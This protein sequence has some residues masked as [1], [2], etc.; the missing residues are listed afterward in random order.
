MPK[1]PPTLDDVRAKHGGLLNGKVYR[2]LKNLYTTNYF[3]AEF[4]GLYST[5]EGIPM[6]YLGNAYVD[7]SMDYSRNIELIVDSFVKQHLYKQHLDQVY[8]FGHAMK[9]YLQAEEDADKG[10][11]FKNLIEWFEMSIPLH[12][13][14]QRSK[15]LKLSGREFAV[16]KDGRYASFNWIKF[17]RSLKNFF[18]GPTMWLKPVTGTIN[19]IF[20]N[21]VTIKE[22]IRNTI[23]GW[24][25]GAN[26]DLGDLAAGYAEAI[27]LYTVDALQDGKFR[28]NK[29]YLLMER[30]GYMP[31]SFD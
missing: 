18:A 1:V 10:I 9:Y 12:I 16:I 27:K 29:A 25:A 7:A 3:E 2:F 8:A 17:L 4:E 30:F 5:E 13:L 11:F 14:G 24:H 21:L 20:A 26:F 31:D 19:A 23:P 15:D 28:E 22:A 6:K